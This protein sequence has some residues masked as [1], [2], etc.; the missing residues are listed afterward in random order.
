[1]IPGNAA[2]Q[3]DNSTYATRVPVTDQPKCFAIPAHTPAIIEFVLDRLIPPLSLMVTA[4]C[5][6]VKP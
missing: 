6:L 1:M 4:T 3:T 5:L 2:E